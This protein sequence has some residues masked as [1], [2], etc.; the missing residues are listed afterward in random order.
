MSAPLCKDC[1]W[2][3]PSD[4]GA[5]YHKCTSPRLRLPEY[6]DL[7]SGG[8]RHRLDYDYCSLQRDP[9]VWRNRCGRH[10]KFFEPRAE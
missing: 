9:I 2:F 8:L 6:E 1:K 10:G 4:F 7:V 3:R 5:D